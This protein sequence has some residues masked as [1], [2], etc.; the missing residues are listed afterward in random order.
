MTTA[1]AR[2]S[3]VSRTT[4]VPARTTTGTTATSTVGRSTSTTGTTIAVVT[5]RVTTQTTA[6]ATTSATTQTTA[7]ATQTQATA[8][9]TQTTQTTATVTQ[10]QTQTQTQSQSQS[11]SQTPTQTPTQTQTQTQTQTTATSKPA[12]TSAQTQTTATSRAAA[13]STQTTATP[14]A[15]S[16]PTSATSTAPVT[17]SATTI[18]STT[19]TAAAARTTTATVTTT[20]IPTS[21]T[22]FP[23]HYMS[24]DSSW[25]CTEQPRNL[26]IN[27]GS[28]NFSSQPQLISLSPYGMQV[29]GP[30]GV[31][32][33]NAAG[34]GHELWKLKNRVLWFT[35][36][37][38]DVQC[39]YNAA[40]YFVAMA[41]NAV[42]GLGYCDAQSTCIEFDAA[43]ANIGGTS[44]SSHS[45][46]GT[47]GGPPCDPWGCGTKSRVT[48]WS[49]VGVGKY[50][51]TTQP[52]TVATTFATNDGTD[53]GT[54]TSITQ[55]FFQ[56]G[57]S[58]TFTIVNEANCAASNP[59]YWS[60]TGRLPAMSRALD[61]GMTLLLTFW[62]TGG[63]SM[64]W[65]DLYPNNSD[66]LSATAGVNTAVWSNIAITR[67]PANAANLARVQAAFA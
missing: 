12:A 8:T 51:D 20:A 25:T 1:A 60:T 59:T 28:F 22:P 63:A 48:D 32:M 65:L 3:T 67:G 43:E 45:C 56:N 24:C 7:T 34:T 42:P 53:T 33:L 30:S 9:T 27:G 57:K 55:T 44:F 35:M 58:Y 5:T 61:A 6:S 47:N 19:T 26:V 52:I 64:S 38:G 11:Q 18:K 29:N 50:I 23:L 54:L 49:S 31:T 39:G 17:T 15:Q 4:T 16:S 14:T 2:T 40:L 36:D 21:L 41:G 13:T 46:G 62:G 10:T 66:C 37:I